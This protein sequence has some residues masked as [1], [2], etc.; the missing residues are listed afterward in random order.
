MCECVLLISVRLPVCAVA[1]LLAPISLLCGSRCVPLT[2]LAPVAVAPTRTLVA[3]CGS[4]FCSYTHNCGLPPLL[5]WL[6]HTHLRILYTLAACRGS[7]SRCAMHLVLLYTPGG[8]QCV[9]LTVGTCS[10]LAPVALAPTHTCSLSRQ[11]FPVC[12]GTIYYQRL[13][14]PSSSYTHLWLAGAAVVQGV[15]WYYYCAM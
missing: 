10:L 3:Y 13:C 12:N 7:L 9:P 5:L 15:Q 6:L 4:C 2:L 14:C 1:A 8:C 11:L